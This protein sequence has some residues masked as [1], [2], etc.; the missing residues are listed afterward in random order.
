[1]I[2]KCTLLK[3]L[4]DYPIG[5]VFKAKQGHDFG[6]DYYECYNY[7]ALRNLVDNPTWVKKEIDFDSCKDLKCPECGG[8]RGI[9][10]GIAYKTGD[11]Y[12]GYRCTADVYFE[13]I[14][15]HKRQLW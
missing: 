5:T 6:V 8:T 3:E 10:T 11:K 13:C 14:C 2:Y 4:P 9:I 1:M 12:D 15:G 7:N